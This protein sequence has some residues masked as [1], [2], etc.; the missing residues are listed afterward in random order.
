MSP[1]SFTQKGQTPKLCLGKNDRRLAWP[2]GPAAFKPKTRDAV[3]GKACG[4][5]GSL[6]PEKKGKGAVLQIR[7]RGGNGAG[8]KMDG[9]GRRPERLG[10]L[11]GGGR[12]QN[13]VAGG[14]GSS[15]KFWLWGG[16][17]TNEWTSGWRGGG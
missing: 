1:W 16:G 2:D 15:S 11:E 6:G 10:G 3:A 4:A 7:G 8:G 17:E 12:A 5:R 14:G 9:G 13:S